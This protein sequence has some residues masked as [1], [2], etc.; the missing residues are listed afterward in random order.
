MKKLLLICLILLTCSARAQE[1]M[2]QEN[3][4]LD[5]PDGAQAPAPTPDG[6]APA[7]SPPAA[8][9][10]DSGAFNPSNTPNLKGGSG[11]NF[12]TSGKKHTATKPPLS[13]AG[14]ADMTNENYPDMIE[15]F[16]FPNADVADVIKAISELTGKN[17]IVDPSV[18]GKI[19][20]MA[21]TQITVAEAYKVFLS[22]LA[23]R[24]FAVV[25]SGKFLKIL[26]VRDAQRDNI[27][28]Y[29]GAYTP[30]TDQMITRII[31][32]RYVP[33]SE[34]NKFA[35]KLV[36]K[37]GNIDIYEPTNS[38]IV[39]DQASSVQRIMKIVAQLDVSSFD[40]Q[41]TVIPIRFAK[42]KDIAD[43]ITQ[44]I[45]KGDKS[46]N[47]SGFNAGIPRFRAG[48]TGSTSGSSAYST[49]I[50]D[51]RTNS[52][53]VVG[54]KDGIDK[55]KKLVGTLDTKHAI[56]A[57]AY[58]YYV[59]FGEAEKIAD[60][61]N[62][63]AKSLKEDAKDNKGAN[64]QGIPPP[65]TFDAFGSPFGQN[66]QAN[67]NNQSSSGLFGADVK[68][69]ADKETNAL[70]I[71]GSKQDYIAVLALLRKIDVARDQV[72]V[73]TVIMEMNM[74]DKNDYGLAYYKFAD[75]GSSGI[76]PRVG[77]GGGVGI[78]TLSLSNV[79]KDGA[80][81]GFGSGSTVS[82]TGPTGSTVQ[83]KSLLGL[84]KLLTRN[85]KTDVL[86]TPQIIA[87][88]N[89]KATVEVGSEVPVG[90][91]T[92][93]AQGTTGTPLQSVEK[94]KATIK[95]E[96]K[97]FIS[98]SSESVRMEIKQSVKQ[99]GGAIEDGATAL[100]TIS[101]SIDERSMETTMV[102]RDGDTA[103]LGGL[104]KNSE[105][106]D[107]SKVPLLGDIPVLGWL[108]KSKSTTVNKNNLIVF[109]TPKVI[110][111]PEDS[112]H[113]LTKKLDERLRYVKDSGGIDKFGADAENLRPKLKT[114][115]KPAINNKDDGDDEDNN[116]DE[117]IEQ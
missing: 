58:V 71:V 75:G 26:P 1:D 110:R 98:P 74:N 53:I 36:S 40:E 22:A 87:M 3:D 31:H 77:F 80:I 14:D 111:N 6:G 94:V 88:D 84:L 117:F 45:N 42:A 8:G 13:Q 51:D 96:I 86:A 101:R 30:D 73:Q 72:F 12:G 4:F 15:S 59:K 48:S 93:G 44:I 9:G 5:S 50:P 57:G 18:S 49:V 39:S 11:G 100:S 16:D 81:L 41:L 35:S 20:I 108:F 19:T 46:K 107:V 85:T 113:L 67:N 91:S 92:T 62:G 99:L 89:Q 104:V 78:D 76:A 79:G 83:V 64:N 2:L 56:Q 97:P 90:L 10:N 29:S 106:V 34:M 37:N 43:L 69:S 27:D 38:L 7:F 66:Q 17:F 103:V 24:G 28:I 112:N 55:I 25:P 115:Q 32:L 61:L 68:I 116:E 105:V 63:I 109:I 95:L 70:I 52:I 65:P 60:I 102:V 21:P 114:A 23:I 54:N 47:N 82:V 33:A